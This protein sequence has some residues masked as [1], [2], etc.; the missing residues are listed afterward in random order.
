L[1]GLDFKMADGEVFDAQVFHLTS[2]HA[3]S[4]Y[5]ERTDGECA[6]RLRWRRFL[7]RG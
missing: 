4:F 1:G 7:R 5:A 3:Q 6:D 2:A